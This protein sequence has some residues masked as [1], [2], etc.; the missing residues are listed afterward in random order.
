[1]KLRKFFWGFLVAIVAIGVAVFSTVAQD[2][3]QP[4]SFFLSLRAQEL[5]SRMVVTPPEGKI[6]PAERAPRDTYGESPSNNKILQFAE[7]RSILFPSVTD[8]Q[9]NL[10]KNGFNVAHIDQTVAQG[11]GP[12]FNATKCL[13]CHTNTEDL[14]RGIGTTRTSSII[15][16]A[17]RATP[18]NLKFANV[19]TSEGLPVSKPNDSLDAITNTG[20]TE[21]FT[22]FGDYDP[23]RHIFDPLAGGTNPISGFAQNFGGLVL[24][25]RA[26]P[27]CLPD[28]LPSVVEDLNLIGA[29][30]ETGIGGVGFKRSIAE[31][32][33]PPYLGRGLMEGVPTIDIINAQDVR[34][35]QLV[36]SSLHRREVFACSGDCVAGRVNPIATT[37]NFAGG[38]GRFGLRANGVELLQF[39]NGGTVG[40]LS[41]TSRITNAEQPFKFGPNKSRSSCVDPL[42]DPDIPLATV[43]SLR[44]FMRLVAPPEFGKE[45]LT[46][47][48]APNPE[49]PL[50]EGGKVA[51]VQQGAKLFGVDLVAFANRMIPGKFPAGGDNRDPNAIERRD[52]GVGCA[53]CHLPVS[54]TGNIPAFGPDVQLVQQHLKN[55]WAAIFSDLLIHRGPSIDAERNAP[56]GRI[57]LLVSRP[58]RNGS[59]FDSFDIARNLA[60]DT[61][62]GQDPTAGRGA[63]PE[64]TPPGE[65][66]FGDEYRTAPLMGL[67]KIGPP[68]MHDGR[69]YLS[70]LTLN[71]TPA[72]TVYSDASVTNAPLVVRNFDDAIRAA[73]ELHD[74]PAPDDSRTP[75]TPGA[76]CPVPPP[77]SAVNVSYGSNPASV[78]CPPYTSPLSTTHRSDAREVIRRYRSL[79][80]EDQQAIIEFLKQL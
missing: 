68:F 67:G 27:G 16:K 51:Q 6:T 61:F 19:F 52:V 12:V 1:M 64:G 47:L 11:I 13:D 32:N 26:I 62:Q 15:G 46:I 69:V 43:Y 3:S 63:K 20:S 74:L 25:R 60:Q 79:S 42:P 10:L 72:S 65:P 75:K 78:I 18:T 73:I 38:V 76:G 31:F 30:P 71:S 33:G 77:G 44:N 5:Q 41:L 35:T 2:I 45:L 59:V 8:E 55:K 54:R 29:D 28:A 66:A 57:P 50:A 58:D 17:K 53:V 37:A 7:L 48:N 21:T 24:H 39:S 22:S 14:P 9:V 36:P 80:G 23:S 49:A 56:I 34:D 4:D 70:T 40:Q